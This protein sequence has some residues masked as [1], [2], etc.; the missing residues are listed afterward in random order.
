MSPSWHPDGVL[1][2]GPDAARTRGSRPADAD[3]GSAARAQLA[4]AL[5][6]LDAVLGVR[7]HDPRPTLADLARVGAARIRSALRRD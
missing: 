6:E 4:A 5:E 7:G 3:S 1:R 2:H